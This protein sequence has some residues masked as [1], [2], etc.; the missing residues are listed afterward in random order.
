MFDKII[1]FSLKYR[2]FIIC[3]ASILVAYG[4]ITARHLPV[5]VLPDLNRP[6]VTI[7]TESAGLAP[8]EV[9]TQVAIP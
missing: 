8:E 6:M 2:L 4:I 9:E 7:M 1:H 5:D 3:V